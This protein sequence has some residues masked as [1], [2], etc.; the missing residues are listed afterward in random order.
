MESN[1]LRTRQVLGH[2]SEYV[3]FSQMA[4][5]C[6]QVENPKISSSPGVH[7][8]VSLK[9]FFFLNQPK[10]PGVL[11][12]I[13]EFSFKEMRGDFFFTTL[14]LL[15]LKVFVLPII[16]C[17]YPI[18]GILGFQFNWCAF[19]YVTNTGKFYQ[20]YFPWKHTLQSRWHW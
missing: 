7:R 3:H 10:N 9:R 12:D 16:L 19:F 6:I 14:V 8:V 20:V 5:M 2:F 1:H 4:L 17:F 13:S 11:E 18:M 15:F